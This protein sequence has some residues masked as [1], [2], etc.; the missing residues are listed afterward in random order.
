METDIM[1][2]YRVSWVRSDGDIII[3]CR[4]SQVRSD[5]DRHNYRL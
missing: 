3:D 2:D 5:R 1:I 4:A